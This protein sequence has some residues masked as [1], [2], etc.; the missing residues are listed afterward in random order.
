[1]LFNQDNTCGL[2]LRGRLWNCNSDDCS[3]G[4]VRMRRMRKFLL[5][6]VSIVFARCASAQ[7]SVWTVQTSGISTNLRG[8]SAVQIGDGSGPSVV[9]ASG[10][11][12]VIL[13]SEDAG[14]H[15]TQ[16]HVKDAD[17]LDFRGIRAF[18]PLVAFVMSVG[19]GDKSRIYK[20]NDGGETWELQ[21]TDKRPAFFLDDIVCLSQTHC[22][23]LGDPIDGKFLIFSTED[24]KTWHELPRDGMPAIIPGE[25]AFAASGTS[26]AIYDRVNL[27]FGTGGGA[28]AR[29]FWSKDLGRTWMVADTPL[30]AGNASSGVFSVVHTEKNVVA[31]GGDYRNPTG[32][33]GVAAYSDDHGTTWR[34]SRT[35]PSGYRSAVA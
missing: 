1:M 13:R 9:W 34:L 16:L 32:T 4:F 29:V 28:T 14:K 10:S 21:Y 2:E 23:A 24:G 12:G 17:T 19:G 11:N 6:L 30:A 26:L 25:G 7:N 31:V 15:W 20:T 18:N 5:I 22:L 8:V 33:I 35:Q 3:R 27:Y